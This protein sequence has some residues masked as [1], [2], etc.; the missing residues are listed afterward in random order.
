M[1]DKVF[2][3]PL[4]KVLLLLA[5][6]ITL[7]GVGAAQTETV[8]FPEIVDGALSDSLFLTT[9]IFVANPSPSA[10]ADVTITFVG[11]D[12]APFSAVFEDSAGTW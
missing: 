1:C 10:T 2:G 3:G 9:T 6:V 8:F 11:Q 12:G 5:L 7:P 4:G